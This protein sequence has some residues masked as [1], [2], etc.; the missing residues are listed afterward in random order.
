MFSKLKPKKQ[1]LLV[2]LQK[3]HDSR[4]YVNTN[5]TEQGKS[6][7]RNELN[8]KTGLK[9]NVI[10][11]HLKAL[12]SEELINETSISGKGQEKFYY[13]TSKGHNALSD[14]VFMWRF[15]NRIGMLLALI[16]SIFGAL[17]SIF[18]FITNK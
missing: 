6:L 18:S 13:L 5:Y 8:I 1:R 16:I 17:N 4:T 7:S 14:N 15:I 12:L 11:N 10:D 2:E 9:I 3:I